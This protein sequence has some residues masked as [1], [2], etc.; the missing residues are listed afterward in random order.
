MAIN[1]SKKKKIILA[2]IAVLV[3]GIGIFLITRKPKESQEEV[4]NLPTQTQ[5]LTIDQMP[6]VRLT[7]KNNS[8]E[9]NLYLESQQGL[10]NN[11][12]EYEL[13]YYPE[14]GPARG[15]L[16]EIE[17]VDGKG[18][19]SVLLG[20]C[21]RDVCRYD[22]GVTGGKVI[23]SLAKNDRLHSFETKFA[24]LTSTTPYQTPEIEISTNQATIIV[25]E[26]GGLPK[27]LADNQELLA[28]P[29][30]I[31][32]EAG[33]GEIDFQLEEGSLLVWNQEGSWEEIEDHQDLSL[34]TYLLV[35]SQ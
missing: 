34:G 24:F 31:T 10:E 7:G 13:I 11:K 14:D 33:E 8:H 30:T 3:F 15:A 23:I 16:G 19:G 2:V 28:G 20:T 22:E 1:L 9:L 12:I 32:A 29:Y 17:L 18:E 26:G 35:S 27:E 25:L 5:P 6:F 21:S 4:G